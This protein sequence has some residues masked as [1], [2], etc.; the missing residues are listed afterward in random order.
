[1]SLKGPVL[2]VC[3]L[4][5]LFCHRKVQALPEVYSKHSYSSVRH[6]K[7][8]GGERQTYPVAQMWE[9]ISEKFLF[10]VVLFTLTVLL[11]SSPDKQGHTGRYLVNKVLGA[12][13]EFMD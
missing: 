10:S 13:W 3:F 4:L 9:F 7:E 1:M 11:G 6:M 12:W 5:V 8:R 2:V